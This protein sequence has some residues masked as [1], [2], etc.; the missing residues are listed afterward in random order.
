MNL[1]KPKF[2]DYKS[3]NIFAYFLL[4]LTIVLRI[5][6]LLKIQTVCAKT[7]IKKICVGNIYLGGT[8]KTSLSIKINQILNRRKLKSC[9]IKKFYRNQIDEQRILK[10]NG[11]LFLSD[12]RTIAL[13]E[14]EN[15]SDLSWAS[16][17]SFKNASAFRGFTIQQLPTNQQGND[18]ATDSCYGVEA[19]S[20]P[21]GQNSQFQIFLRESD[22]VAVKYCSDPAKAGCGAGNVWQ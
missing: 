18:R 2:W 19:I 21:A 8:G 20:N 15:E 7:K 22:G 6:N 12:Q 3:P 1:K 5:Y 10:N 4:P 13:R 14:A 17:A 16:V 9:F 11:K